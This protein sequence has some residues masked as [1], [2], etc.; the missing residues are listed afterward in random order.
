MA[1]AT[2]EERW[3]KTARLAGAAVAA[4]LVA[5]LVLAI[6][7]GATAAEAGF[8][9]AHILATLALSAVP[10]ALVFWHADRHEAIDRAHGLY[11]D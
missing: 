10:A 9:L 5:A 4:A 11:E 6:L 7:A 1:D 2:Q 3:R 8:P